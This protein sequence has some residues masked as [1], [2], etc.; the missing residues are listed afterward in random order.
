MRE[1]V[2]EDSQDSEEE[3]RI[4]EYKETVEVPDPQLEMLSLQFVKK[5]NIC[6]E[7]WSLSEL[8][9][10]LQSIRFYLKGMPSNWQIS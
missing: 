6:Y 1:D 9:E 7:A 8:Q 4:T 2:A 5:D 3:G 10:T